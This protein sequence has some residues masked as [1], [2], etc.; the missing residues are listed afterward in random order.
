MRR[1]LAIS[2]SAVALTALVACG[3]AKTSS[4]QETV[5]TSVSP[6]PTLNTNV[7][8]VAD[9][10]SVAQPFVADIEEKIES[11]NEYNC[12]NLPSASEATFCGAY[13]TSTG[14]VARTIELSL[15]GAMKPSAPAYIGD[16]PPELETVMNKTLESAK[17]AAEAAESYSDSDCPDGEGCLALGMELERELDALH[18]QLVSWGNY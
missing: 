15:Q 11:L 8:S 5:V 1:I 12:F 6:S 14:Y 3:G 2:A 16:L 17:N 9:Y 18:D 7:G 4:T 10:K 13:G